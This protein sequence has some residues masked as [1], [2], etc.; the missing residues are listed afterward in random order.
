MKKLEVIDETALKKTTQPEVNVENEKASEGRKIEDKK[1]QITDQL[2]SRLS[3]VKNNNKL[4][5]LADNLP[6]IRQKYKDSKNP[7]QSVS[8]L[9]EIAMQ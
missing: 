1:I 3:E 5:Q 8:V 2:S 4:E 9:S 6:E 7:S